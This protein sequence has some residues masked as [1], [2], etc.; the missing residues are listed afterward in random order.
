VS[1]GVNWVIFHSTDTKSDIFLAKSIQKLLQDINMKSTFKVTL[2]GMYFVYGCSILHPILRKR[3]FCQIATI[4]FS[5]AC[6][7]L[8]SHCF[9]FLSFSSMCHCQLVHQNKLAQKDPPLKSPQ[10]CLFG[11][12]S[13]TWA[14]DTLLLRVGD[15]GLEE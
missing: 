15:A 14:H 6:L 9:D 8:L 13:P 3:C 11:P 7:S 1:T 4:D 10:A 5:G 2:H 12:A